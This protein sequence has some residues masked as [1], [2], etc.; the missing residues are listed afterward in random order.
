MSSFVRCPDCGT[1]VYLQDEQ[2]GDKL[3]CEECGRRFTW[4]AD[5]DAKDR[6][7]RQRPR[8]RDAADRIQTGMRRIRRKRPRTPWYLFPIA[9]LPLLVPPTVG[10]AGLISGAS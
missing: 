10:A 9:C 4:V 5:E 3:C 6:A 8:D 2:P 7:E 1:K